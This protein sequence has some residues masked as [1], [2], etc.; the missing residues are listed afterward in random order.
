VSA[1][2]ARRGRS[3][4]P[5][6]A[7]TAVLTL[8]EGSLALLLPPYLVG[9]ALPA[10]LVGV[11]VTAYGVAS[12]V[13]RVP[14]GLLY[15]ARHATLLIAAG[16]VLSSGAFALIPL[17]GHPALVAALVALDGLGFGL[18]ST[19]TMAA[20]IDRRPP[21]AAAGSIMGWY[22]G[23][24]GAGYAGAGFLA[25]A[26]GDG[27]GPGPAMLVLAVVPLVAATLLGAALRWAPR[28]AADRPAAA[29]RGAEDR[30]GAQ[31][32]SRAGVIARLRGFR[33]QPALVWVAFLVSLYINLASGVLN[34]YFPL[35][36]LSIGLTLTQ[37]GMLSGIH[38]ILAAVVRF[39]SGPLFGLIS[40]RAALPVMVIVSGA[41]VVAVGLVT[42]L[43]LLA[44]SWGIV[45]LARGILRV[46]SSA[47][48]MEAAGAA[49]ADR[50]AASGIYLAGLDLGKIVGPAVGA[51][52]VGLVG[53]RGTFLI[54]GVAFPAAYLGIAAALT[55]SGAH[56][57]GEGDPADDRERSRPVVAG[58]ARVD[59][60]L[61][62]EP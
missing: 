60:A 45:G 36:G 1:G 49:D 41:G 56:G 50:G 18:A 28:L 39:G 22:T 61:P 13:S 37:I 52:S 2:P 38:G 53:L 40:Y 20:L 12:L 21:G 58:G 62:R 44:V 48:V 31:A 33:H 16:C 14:A 43:P 3:L 9:R 29:A 46:A 19:A 55:R 10:G 4:V 24:L 11:V 23:S 15:R 32:G 59:R 17:T 57:A 8:G 34:T 27:L 26:L 7:A 25:G 54:A 5:L 30:R 51:L 6:Y 35:Y 47:L 42:M